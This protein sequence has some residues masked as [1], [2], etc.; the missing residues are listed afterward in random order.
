MQKVEFNNKSNQFLNSLNDD[1]KKIKNEKKVYVPADKTNN[2]YLMNPDDYH[3]LLEKNAQSKYRK[4]TTEEVNEVTKEHQKL[5]SDLDMS[6][7]V[8]KTSCRASV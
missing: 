6:E 3:Q 5:V 4:A 1:L 2:M 7:R 8:M